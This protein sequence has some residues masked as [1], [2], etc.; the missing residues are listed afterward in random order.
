MPT[1][2]TKYVSPKTDNSPQGEIQC[3]LNE[4][5]QRGYRLLPLSINV[6]GAS[7]LVMERAN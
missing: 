7:L 6:E 5:A 1:Y 3:W 2:E 4:M